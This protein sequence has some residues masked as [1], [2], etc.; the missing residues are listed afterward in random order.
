MRIH[1]VDNGGPVI[2]TIYNINCKTLYNS[3]FE[4]AESSIYV[5]STGSGPVIDQI[6]QNGVIFRKLHP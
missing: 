5:P 1:F 6:E 2:L 4:N 3:K